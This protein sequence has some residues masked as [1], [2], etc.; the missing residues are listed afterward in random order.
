M[1]VTRYLSYI[2][3]GVLLTAGQVMAAPQI[4]S[5]NGAIG[6]NQK[7]NLSGIGFGTKNQA[8]PLKYDDFESGTEGTIVTG[9]Y[10]TSNKAGQEPKYVT[11]IRK[12]GLAEKSVLQKFGSFSGNTIYNS[13]LGLTNINTGKLYLSGWFY[14]TT[15]GAASRNFKIFSLRGGSPGKWDPPEARADMYPSIN[16][17]QMYTA[18]TTNKVLLTSWALGGNL[19]SGSWHRFEVWIDDNDGGN[20]GSYTIWLDGKRWASIAGQI[21]DS[22]VPYTNMYLASY[23]AVDQG[24][25]TPGLEFFWDEVYVDKTLARL[26][27]GNSPEWSKCTHKQIQLPSEWTAN[28]IQ[29]TFKQGSFNDGDKVYLYVVDSNGN[30]NNNGY[31]LTIGGTLDSPTIDPPKNLLVR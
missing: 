1:R 10:T 30:V 19:Q 7:V 4:N 29:F 12:P 14:N 21:K 5:V 22:S 25:P 26:E 16:A 31:P 15:S 23:F 17:G 18:S 6:H 3:A 11:K 27:I 2:I 13:T 20:N 8:A 9:W 24:S 28:S